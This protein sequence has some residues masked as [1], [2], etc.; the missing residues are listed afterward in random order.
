MA[1]AGIHSRWVLCARIGEGRMEEGAQVMCIH[2]VC[3]N[4]SRLGSEL[5][6]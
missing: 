1:V 2:E 3:L 6:Y 5:R 4:C